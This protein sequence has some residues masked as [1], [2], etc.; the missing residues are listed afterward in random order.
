MTRRAAAT[1]TQSGGRLTTPSAT[2]EAL[3]AVRLPL[4]KNPPGDVRSVDVA[5]WVEM[6]LTA[7][8][9]A[10]SD[11][12]EVP[13]TP[14]ERPICSARKGGRVKKKRGHRCAANNPVCFQFDTLAKRAARPM[15]A[16]LGQTRSS[17]TSRH[18]F[19]VSAEDR[20]FNSSRKTFDGGAGSAGGFQPDCR[21]E[22][23]AGLSQRL[24][25]RT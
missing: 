20:N 12:A 19:S 1:I 16:R 5:Q 25:R 14:K 4:E 8:G 9:I 3:I 7:G 2:D 24:A 23:C 17:F 18:V 13:P 6:A 15:P 21:W 10:P 11:A 22:R